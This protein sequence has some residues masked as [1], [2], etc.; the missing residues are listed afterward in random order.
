MRG[1]HQWSETLVLLLM[2]PEYRAC[3]HWILEEHHKTN[4]L[5]IISLGIIIAICGRRAPLHFCRGRSSMPTMKW[6]R[7]V[8]SIR[9]DGVE[10]V[11]IVTPLSDQ[12]LRVPDRAL[13]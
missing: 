3:H 8:L 2:N 12:A 5:P 13:G 7:G 9:V 6:N 11:T 10:L 1:H 4:R